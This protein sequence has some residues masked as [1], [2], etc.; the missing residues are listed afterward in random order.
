MTALKGEDGLDN[1]I[2]QF[3]RETLPKE[4]ERVLEYVR[5]AVKDRLFFDGVW[6]VDYMRLRFLAEKRL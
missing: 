3:C 4:P 1:W 5:C 2:R 6:H